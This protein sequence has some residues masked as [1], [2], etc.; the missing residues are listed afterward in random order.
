MEWKPKHRCEG[1][2]DDPAHVILQRVDRNSEPGKN[3]AEILPMHSTVGGN[4]LSQSREQR[5]LSRRQKKPNYFADRHGLRYWWLRDIWIVIG[6]LINPFICCS[7]LCQGCCL[8]PCSLWRL[9]SPM[10]LVSRCATHNFFA[11]SPSWMIITN[12][13]VLIKPPDI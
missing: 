3:V 11:F 8:D 6:Q 7:L 5:P 4:L 13:I 1:L 12:L 9:L 2:T 10:G